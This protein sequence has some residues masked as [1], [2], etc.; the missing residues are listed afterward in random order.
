MRVIEKRML[1]AIA[2]GK[3]FKSGNTQVIFTDKDNFEVRLHGNKI[4]VGNVSEKSVRISHA[5]WETNTTKSRLNALLSVNSIN[6]R[7]FVWYVDNE[8]EFNDWEEVFALN[9]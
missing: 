9:I 8:K 6:Q 3:S 7:N 1:N 5:G 2:K 4:A